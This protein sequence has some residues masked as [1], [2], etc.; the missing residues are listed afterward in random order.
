MWSADAIFLDFL[1]CG[2][3]LAKMKNLIVSLIV[4]LFAVATMPANAQTRKGRMTQTE[5]SHMNKKSQR[6]AKKRMRA[7]K[8]DLTNVKCTTRQS[9]RY[10]RKSG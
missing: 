4:V 8:G 1:R 7:A 6:W 9:R 10:A 5:R 2:G 3:N